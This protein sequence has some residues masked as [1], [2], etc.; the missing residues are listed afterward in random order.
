MAATW[1]SKIENYIAAMPACQ[2]AIEKAF[3][4]LGIAPSGD[5]KVLFSEGDDAVGRDGH[6][7]RFAGFE[8]R[9]DEFADSLAGS[10]Q[11]ARAEESGQGEPAVHGRPAR[12]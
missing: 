3:A 1:R 6:A 4:L 2:N 5:D 7:D 11:E 12:P 8:G 9:F 10:G